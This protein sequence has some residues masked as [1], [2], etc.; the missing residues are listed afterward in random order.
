MSD[1]KERTTHPIN[2]HIRK[3]QREKLKEQR[4]CAGDKACLKS[5]YETRLD[6]NWLASVLLESK[7]NPEII[8]WSLAKIDVSTGE[9]IVQEG[10]ESNNLRQEL[11]K[12]NA[13]EVISEK[14]SIQEAKKVDSEKDDAPKEE[15]KKKE[16]KTE[17][18]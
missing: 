18:K 12:L 9:F 13:A 7:S 2:E 11:I 5:F 8:H 3:V 1:L 16:L 14:K 15:L 6:V 10:Q 17:K 4:Q